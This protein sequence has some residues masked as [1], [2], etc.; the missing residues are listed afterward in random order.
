[1]FLKLIRIITRFILRLIARVE[2]IDFDRVLQTESVIVVTNHLGRLDAILGYILVDRAD[3]I[4]MVAEKY[5]K[6]A[7]WRWIGSKLN[8]IWLNRF[9]AD[10]HALRETTRRLKQGGILAVAP[11]GTRSPTEAL[12]EG[13]PGAAFLAAKAGVP[14][15]PVV[16]TGTEDRV[17][18]ERLR[19][20]KRLNITIRVG[21]PFTLP[22]MD[23]K[24]RDAYLTEQTEE[25]M[26]RIAACL[27]EKYRGVYAEHPRLKELLAKTKEAHLL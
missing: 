25:I 2:L 24:N 14:L 22:P 4:M 23:R 6:V 13:K 3:V 18:L 21:E 5:E 20:F 9:E 12:Q 16:L 7:L 26:C 17:V 11:E 10:I 15:L 8:V 19:H 27:P 1:M